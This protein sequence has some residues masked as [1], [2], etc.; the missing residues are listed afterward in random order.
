VQPN[1]ASIARA[2][3]LRATLAV[4]AAALLVTGCASKQTASSGKLPKLLI[5]TNAEGAVPAAAAA[6]APAPGGNAQGR[7]GIFP[8]YVIAGTL[9]DQPTHAPIYLWSSTKTSQADVE[10]LGTALGLNGTPSRHAYGWDLRT[11]AGELRVRDDRGE[12]WSYART[13]TSTCPAYQVDIDN[14]DN[15]VSGVGCAV[16]SAG[17]TPADGPD[18]TTTKGAAAGLLKALGITG[19]EQFSTGAPTS[20]LNVSPTV[21]GLSTQ[22]IETNINV[23][24]KGIVAATGYLQTLKPGDDY[25]L[26]TAKAAFDS[27]AARPQPMIA[28]YCGPIPGGPN[29]FGG[30]APSPATVTGGT[31]NG[32]AGAIASAPPAVP[33]A[34]VAPPAVVGPGKPVGPPVPVNSVGVGSP[35]ADGS[36]PIES[37]PV[38]C[39]TPEPIKITG[40]KLG[41]EIEYNA[42]SDGATILVPSWFFP[43]ADGSLA[44]TA[45]AVDPSYLGTPP[46]PTEFPGGS[47]DGSGGGGGSA[48]TAIPPAAPSAVGP[49]AAVS[50]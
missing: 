36:A 41:L 2:T 27:L 40:A 25:P 50:S 17:A 35:P 47:S 7:M 46:P 6:I 24:A 15:A 18:E 45:I 10:K 11:A 1:R 38:P 4:A 34:A 33:S 8:G 20:Y 26:Q 43:L 30:I 28:Q 39:P 12:Q 19:D 48:F 42:T 49:S 44:T 16:A 23:D 32:G 31:A 14:P 22:G 13:D 5:A 3:L 29:R 37:S 9:P 21:A